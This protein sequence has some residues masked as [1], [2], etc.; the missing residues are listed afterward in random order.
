LELEG[1]GAQPWRPFRQ[2]VAFVS[3][4]YGTQMVIV[5][6]ELDA[7]LRPEV[8][9]N[10]DEF[11][12]P[13]YTQ[14]TA[15]RKWDG[16]FQLPVG[17]PVIITAGY[18]IARAYNDGGYDIYHTGIDFAA[19]VGTLTFAPANGVVV[20]NDDLELRGKTI[21]INHG[22]GVMTGY[23]HLER[24]LVEVGQEVSAGQMIGEIGSTGLSSGPHLHWDLRIMDVPV[25]GMQWTRREFP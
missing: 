3:A 20:F 22:L 2:A 15:E 8:R 12:R 13:I 16:L 1:G 18:G 21:I 17:E 4:N 25:N 24:S 9:R 5:P 6:P 11:L 10:E 14:F 19:A 23:F 7:L